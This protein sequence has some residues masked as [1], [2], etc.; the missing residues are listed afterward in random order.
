MIPV[1]DD[2]LLDDAA[3]LAA[4][5]TAGFLRS[6]A[7]A[8]A[9]LRAARQAAEEAGV[10][11]ALAG[12]QPRSLV[13]LRR[14]GTSR[15]A[16][17]ILAA[18]LGEHCPVPV[19]LA[20][21]APS[22]I[23]PLDVLVAH[24]ADPGDRELADSVHRAGQRG[25]EVVLSAP[26]EGP[27]ATAAA[28]S[29]RLLEPRVPVPPGLDLPR[30]L[31]TG[32]VTAAAL[33]LLTVDLEATAAELDRELERDHPSHEPFVN[34]AKT[35][36]L[37]LADRTPLLWGTDAVAGEVAGYAAAT[38]ARNAGVVAHAA[39]VAEAAGATA[40]QRVLAA[41]AEHAD[42]FH[43]PFDDPVPGAGSAAPPR[44]MLL[45]T[46][47][48]DPTDAVLRRAGRSWPEADTVHP[49][50]EVPPGTPHGV[51]LRA[52]LI[53]TRFDLAALYLGLAGSLLGADP[54]D[55]DTAAQLSGPA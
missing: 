19:V 42:V 44:L 49:V 40:L 8:G 5:D 31:A 46:S 14:P 54:R 38:L 4:A 24:T 33:G 20:D 35:L 28:G 50:E 9:Q 41:A 29:A 1:P 48:S 3:A 26:S 23:G 36:A 27:I 37:Q 2:T 32:L 51:L 55:P 25:C 6:A 53:A 21:N 13:L 18:L 11:A 7:T 52:A 43:D 39:D 10:A 47:D 12:S 45:S 22:W 30:A 17:Q 15:W 34:P 16:A